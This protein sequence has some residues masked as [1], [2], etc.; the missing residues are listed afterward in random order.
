MCICSV[1]T[2]GYINVWIAGWAFVILGLPFTDQTTAIEDIEPIDPSN[3]L[4]LYSRTN[5]FCFCSVSTKGY[6][7]VWIAGWAFVILRLPFTDQ[8]TAIEDIEPIDPSNILPLYSRTDHFCFC[9]V[10]TKGYIKVWI[11]GW[12][13]VILRLP[14]TDQTTA[15]EDIEP[16]DPSN[17]LPL[18]SRTN[19]F[20]FCSVST[21]GYIKVWIAGWAFVILGLPFTDQTTAIEDIEPI[22]PSNILPLYSRTNHFCFCS[23]STKGY[24]KVWI[25][26]WAFVILGLPFTDQTTAIE[27]IEP[28]DPSNI[29]PLYS[30]TNHFCFCSVL[31]KGYIK[32]FG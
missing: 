22:D 9:S 5:H 11:A 31:T 21:K 28:I 4:P 29:L 1:S 7:K 2:K 14:F 6:I 25:A 3:I 26:G 32:K 12:A 8:T 17:I 24:I 16:I 20:C 23:V 27:D 10:S 15:I 30:R 13:F 18:Y 19:H